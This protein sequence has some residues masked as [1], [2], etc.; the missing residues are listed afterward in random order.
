MQRAAVRVDRCLAEFR[1]GRA[2]LITDPI[3][4]AVAAAAETLSPDLLRRLSSED[5]Q[6]AIAITA[7]RARTLGIL[8]DDGGIAIPLGEAADLQTIALAVG[9]AESS[10]VPA[11][12]N[13]AAATTASPLVSAALELARRARLLPAV[14]FT[15]SNGGGDF[16]ELLAVD[17]SDVV[18]LLQNFE[19]RIV[20]VSEARVPLA[21]HE[22]CELVLFREAPGDLEH[23]AVMIGNPDR[24]APVLVRLHSACLTGDLLSS[25][26]CD[27]GDQLR[28]A[29]NR[30][31]AA[32]G[33]LLYLAHEGR[34]IGLANKLR[35]YGLQDNGLDTLDADRHLGFRSDERDFR[36]AAAMLRSLGVVRIRLLTN[37]PDKIE[38]MR[39]GG[40]D[41]VERVPLVVPPNA[42]N[43]RYLQTKRE[44]A[45]HLTGDPD[46]SAR[47]GAGGPYHSKPN[48]ALEV[49]ASL[50]RPV[51]IRPQE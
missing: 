41:V 27:C 28:G 26:R 33:I 23:L 19:G 38:T 45:G 12:L 10:G 37:N 46:Q 39:E 48:N 9:L 51:P 32:G 18:A 36:A 4:G 25:L 24:S 8:A 2:V 35:A 42:H 6:L 11:G 5:A 34:G 21:G 43:L 15:H 20:R 49:A 3:S 14:V 31:G 7:E 47:G 22:N 1:R 13:P 30:L 29:V 44:R 40:V 16:E 50:S 17:A